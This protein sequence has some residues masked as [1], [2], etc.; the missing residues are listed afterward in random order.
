MS[1][2]LTL[3]QSGNTPQNLSLVGQ[4]GPTFEALSQRTTSIIQAS[5][6]GTTLVNSEDLLIGRTWNMR[7][8]R[9]PYFRPESQPPVS[10]P[11]PNVGRPYFRV[12]NSAGTFINPYPLTNTY[13]GG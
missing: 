11:N 8:L 2:L 6:N 1:R 5:V 3:L 10:L 4:P 9:T 7:G 13:T 12:L